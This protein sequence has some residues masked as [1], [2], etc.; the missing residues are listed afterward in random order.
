MEILHQRHEQGLEHE[1]G[2][3][4]Q[5]CSVRHRDREEHGQWVQVGLQIEARTSLA[6]VAA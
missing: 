6:A 2:Q 5:P 3:G 4:P 1:A